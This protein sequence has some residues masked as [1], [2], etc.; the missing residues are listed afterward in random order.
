MDC[1]VQIVCHY[2][3]DDNIVAV[4]MWRLLSSDREAADDDDAVVGGRS[5][6]SRIGS[7]SDDDSDG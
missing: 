2:R 7:A 4:N 1:K 6:R 5:T 3:Q